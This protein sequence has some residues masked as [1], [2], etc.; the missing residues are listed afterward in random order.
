MA[1]QDT[2]PAPKPTKGYGK[3]SKGQWLL[4]YVVLAIIVYGLVYLVF[5]RKSGSGGFSY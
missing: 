3:R 4:I 1:D 2:S 5:F